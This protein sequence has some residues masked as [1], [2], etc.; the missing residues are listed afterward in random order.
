MQNL[1][2]YLISTGYFKHSNG[3]EGDTWTNDRAQSSIVSQWSSTIGFADIPTYT[4]LYYRFFLQS[5]YPTLSFH[6]YCCNRSI[7]RA[8]LPTPW[9]AVASPP[10]PSLHCFLLQSPDS[11]PLSLFPVLVQMPRP[12]SPC[13]A[14]SGCQASPGLHTSMAQRPGNNNEREQPNLMILRK[15]EFMCYI[16]VMCLSCIFFIFLRQWL[17]IWPTSS[18]WSPRKPRKI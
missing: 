9:W 13:R 8:W 3:L 15:Y 16:I 11:P 2:R 6:T 18:G 17:R 12:A 7:L 10:R 5:P 1:L 14:P 4:Y